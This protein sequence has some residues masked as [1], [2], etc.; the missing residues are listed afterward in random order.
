MLAPHFS[1]LLVWQSDL[2]HPTGA[3]L[4]TIVSDFS[5]NLACAD[6]STYARLRRYFRC[7]FHM[8]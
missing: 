6:R 3:V 4:A 2:G 1:G 5:Q 8:G 7:A